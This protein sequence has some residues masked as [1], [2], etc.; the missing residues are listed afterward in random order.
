[1]L[2]NR[3]KEINLWHIL[4][5]VNYP[6]KS[7]NF[8]RFV[9]KKQYCDGNFSMKTAPTEKIEYIT[10]KATENT[11]KLVPR[12][13][14]FFLIFITEIFG[15]NPFP[16]GVVGQYCFFQDFSNLSKIADFVQQITP[17]R[18]CQRFISLCLFCSI[19]RQLCHGILH[20]F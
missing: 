20:F 10:M 6:T 19:F 3:H 18:M 4:G 17:P 7:D 14:V 1:M 15:L 16:H 2:Q 5:G 8:D 9:F 11:T 12:L 13:F